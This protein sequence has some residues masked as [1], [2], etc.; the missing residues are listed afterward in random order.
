M[1]P[2]ILSFI[3]WICFFILMASGWR[4]V[5]LRHVSWRWIICIG[6]SWILLNRFTVTIAAAGKVN[7]A[8]LL[9]CLV[10]VL[11][12][13]DQFIRLRGFTLL[14]HIGLVAAAWLW[15]ELLK[16][17]SISLLR[18]FSKEWII[19]AIIGLM[20]L[21]ASRRWTY[22]WIVLTLGLAC[23]DLFIKAK[24][25]ASSELGSAGLQDVWWVS[26]LTV[27]MVTAAMQWIKGR[28]RGTKWK[29]A[30]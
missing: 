26:F 9:W 2:G 7:A 21:S 30:D 17:S 8:W 1:T 10:A 12:L 24:S 4:T 5:V 22:Q 14:G 18:Q 6:V 23:G 3:V 15:L 13:L 28:W 25:G 11:L 20:V 19:A 27:R 29:Q 16:W